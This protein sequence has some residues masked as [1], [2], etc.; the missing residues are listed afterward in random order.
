M[1]N[2]EQLKKAR[3]TLDDAILGY[4]DGDVAQQLDEAFAII[5]KLIKKEEGEA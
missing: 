1:K 4:C 3:E 5:D 2:L